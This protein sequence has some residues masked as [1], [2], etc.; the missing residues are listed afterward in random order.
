MTALL[1][2]MW[3]GRRTIP[4]ITFIGAFSGYFGHNPAPICPEAAA[5]RGGAPS[6]PF[7]D[8]FTGSG[9]DGGLSKPARRSATPLR[10][11]QDSAGGIPSPARFLSAAASHPPESRSP[12]IRHPSG[13]GR[14]Y[15]GLDG[16]SWSGG[17]M[18]IPGW[19]RPGTFPGSRLESRGERPSSSAAETGAA[20]AVGFCRATGAV[21][22]LAVHPQYRALGIS[23]QLL[24][25]V[26]RRLSSERELSLTT[27]R[28]RD[29]ADPATG[30]NGNA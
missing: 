11:V 6:C 13:G 27:F 1:L 20:G 14:G 22:Y 10:H 2:R 12:L 3:H 30:G 17:G 21:D 7:P 26:R 8:A 15:P 18:G 24:K 4:N 19:T 16:A 28:E 9:A 25:A 29:P 23:V 5:D